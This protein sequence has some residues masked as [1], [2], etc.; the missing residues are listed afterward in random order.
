MVSNISVGAASVAVAARP[1]LPNTDAT[2]GKPLI[3]RSCVCISSAALVMDRPGGVT[4]MN[5]SVPSFSSGMNS[6]P[7]WR[8]G[9]AVTATTPAA[10]TTSR[11]GTRSAP[12]ISGR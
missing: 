3:T 11:T 8:A 10:S 6:L 4:G 1:A 5:S 7:S 2:S 12:R 9:Q